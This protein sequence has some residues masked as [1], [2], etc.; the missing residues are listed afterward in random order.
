MFRQVWRY[1]RWPVYVVAVMFLALSPVGLWPAL[2][3]L[4]LHWS[5]LKIIDE[6]RE[7]IMTLTDDEVTAFFLI[8]ED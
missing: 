6:G 4:C 3:F 8:E 7:A 1:A 2:I 5:F